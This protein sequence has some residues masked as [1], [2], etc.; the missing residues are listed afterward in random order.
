MARKQQNTTPS[1]QGESKAK[2]RGRPQK[3]YGARLNDKTMQ[4]AARHGMK[5]DDED[6]EQLVGMIQ[7]DEKT[8]DMAIRLQRSFYSAQ[9]ARSHVGFIMRHKAAFDRAMA[10]VAKPAKRTR[11][12]SK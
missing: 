2:R 6:V 1:I 9:V 3:S 11:K 8:F 7:S 4:T 5:W 12:A 10:A